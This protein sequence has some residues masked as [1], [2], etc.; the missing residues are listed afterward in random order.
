MKSYQSKQALI[1]AINESYDRLVQ[2][3]DNIDSKLFDTRHDGVDKTP[4]EIIAYQIG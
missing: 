3:Y 1:D 2:E 4:R